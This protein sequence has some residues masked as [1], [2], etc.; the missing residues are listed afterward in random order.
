MADVPIETV[1]RTLAER[2][3]AEV[4][5]ELLAVGLHAAGLQV[6]AAYHPAEVVRLG[7]AIAEAQRAMLEG[8]SSPELQALAELLDPLLAGAT[9]SL[10]KQSN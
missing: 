6:K 4:A 10:P 9:S 1:L 2:V 8:S 7:G 3:G 5:D